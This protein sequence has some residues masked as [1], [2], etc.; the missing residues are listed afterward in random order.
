MPTATSPRSLYRDAGM[1][2]YEIDVIEAAEARPLRRALLYGDRPVTDADHPGDTHPS[3]RHLGA[4]KDGVLVGTA[5]IHPQPMPGA[6]RMG[7]W[8]IRDIAVE[9]GHRGRGVGALL[10]ERVLEHASHHEG[11]VAWATVRASAYGFFERYGFLRSGSPIDDPQEG[12]Q[13][14]MHATIRPL[15]RSWST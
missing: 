7:A 8:R 10:L 5:T 11:A 4:F 6:T 14:L 12:P 3:A 2:D 15:H 13:Y 9:H 1:S